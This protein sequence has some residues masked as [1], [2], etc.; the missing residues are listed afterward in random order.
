MDNRADRIWLRAMEIGRR[1]GCHQMPERSFF[2]KGRQFPVCARCTGVFF[3]WFVSVA[4]AWLYRPGL[5]VMAA[6]LA[7]M[8][9]DWLLQ[10]IDVLESGNIR[11]FVTGALAGYAIMSAYVQIIMFVIKNLL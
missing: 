4:T 11:R 2:I 7:V 5:L 8:F 10:R 9:L 1:T 3:G 6:F